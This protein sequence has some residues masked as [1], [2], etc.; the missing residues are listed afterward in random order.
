MLVGFTD[1]ATTGYD[2]RYD[3]KKIL[4]PGNIGVY[5]LLNNDPYVI[6]CFPDL[7]TNKTIEVGVIANT[8]DT[9]SIGLKNT[10]NLPNGTKLYLE[11]NYTNSYHDLDQ[12]PYQIALNQDTFE[13]RFFLHVELLTTGQSSNERDAF[14]DINIMNLNKQLI[15]NKFPSSSSEI[16][17][18]DLSGKLIFKENIT[19]N[20]FKKQ[21]NLNGVYIIKVSNNDNNYCKKVLLN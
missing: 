14:S 6:Q 15:I 8:A 13:N 19:G 10:E 18:Y 3:G 1:S 20:I 11:D 4:V 2:R 21:H 7:T 12:G 9:Y 17:I 5:S 16:S